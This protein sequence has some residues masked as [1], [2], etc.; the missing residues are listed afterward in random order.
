MTQTNSDTTGREQQPG[1]HEEWQ[2]MGG[3]LVAWGKP[4]TSSRRDVAAFG[5]FDAE[6]TVA[7]T[8][9]AA[10]ASTMDRQDG[11]IYAWCLGLVDVHGY[12]LADAGIFHIHLGG[13]RIRQRRRGSRCL[14]R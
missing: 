11:G 12:A 5:E 9:S 14:L 8:I 6:R 2:V 4:V 10:E 13:Y 3:E 7:L 1:T